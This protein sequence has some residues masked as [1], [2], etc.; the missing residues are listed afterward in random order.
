MLLENFDFDLPSELIA[1]HPVYPRDTS[2]MLHVSGTTILDKNIQD[3]VSLI[4]PNDV[5]VFNN[6]K[7]IPSYIEGY[8]I[9][10]LNQK[11]AISI[12]LHQCKNG[13]TWSAFAKPGKK[14]HKQKKL[15]ITE[16]F[17][18]SVDGFNEETGEFILN[19]NISGKSFFDQLQKHG[20][21][22]LPQ[23]IKRD[24]SSN[25]NDITSYQ[26]TFA[27]KEG[28]VAAPTAGLHFSKELLKKIEEKNIKVVFVTLH[29]GGGTFL[30]VKS[31]HIEN[32][33]MHSEYYEICQETCNI[34]NEAKSNNNRVIT[35]GTTSL[36]VLETIASKNTILQPST[37]E[38]DIFIYPGYEFKLVDIL[39][40][41][42]HLPKSTLFM[43]VS[44]FS[45]LK[46][47]Q[48]AYQHAI[49]SKYRFF[50][51]GDACWLEKQ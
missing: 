6:T 5:L 10:S 38:T 39:I 50:S 2:K 29:V 47:M 1:Q 25:H 17:F 41:N 44:A 23:Y 45:G 31:D 19:F 49:E 46:T 33:K 27:K 48:K 21:M 35:V 51:Y 16:D 36:R 7:V 32:H 12:N 8:V 43:L 28:A 42:F 26:T 37:G 20:K 18:A 22:P 30:P 24:N 40:T 15:Y 11:S 14:L 34:I 13:N 3:I 4:R 9:N